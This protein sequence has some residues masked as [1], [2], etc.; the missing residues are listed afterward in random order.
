MSTKNVIIPAHTHTVVV[1]SPHDSG[2][3]TKTHITLEEGATLKHF[4]LQKAHNTQT[5]NIE[6]KQAKNSHYQGTLIQYGSDNIKTTLHVLLNDSAAI[7]TLYALTLADSQQHIETHLQVSHITANSQSKITTRNLVKHHAKSF[8]TGTIT[9]HPNAARTEASLDDKNLLLSPNAEARTR[10]Q[11]EIYNND[12]LC[13]HGATV[14][15]LEEEALFYLM[16][17]GISETQAKFLLI[18]AF[19]H[20]ILKQLPQDLLN[21]AEETLHEYSRHC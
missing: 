21:Q 8:F 20:P 2:N 7:C 18:E 15:H 3:D 9:V 5:T 13:S 17:R 16:S 12:I 1:E 11:L 6:V 10:P 19:V 4:I 14:G